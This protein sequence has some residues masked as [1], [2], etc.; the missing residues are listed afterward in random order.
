MDGI[1]QVRSLALSTDFQ[2]TQFHLRKVHSSLGKYME[3]RLLLLFSLN[4]GM[5]TCGVFNLY[6]S[7]HAVRRTCYAWAVLS[8]K[9]LCNRFTNF[10][11]H[12][13]KRYTFSLLREKFCHV[14]EICCYLMIY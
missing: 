4:S 6:C 5:I 10:T 14:M 12:W 7:N 3:H 9:I 8:L 11:S 13:K 2:R 1:V